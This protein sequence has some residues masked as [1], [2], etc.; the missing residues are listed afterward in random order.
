MPSIDRDPF[1]DGEALILA[2]SS[3]ISLYKLV[4]NRFLAMYRNRDVLSPACL[5][6][7]KEYML[8][9][10]NLDLSKFPETV[11]VQLKVGESWMQILW[12]Q[13]ALRG[14]SLSVSSPHLPLQ[15]HFPALLVSE[16]LQFCSGRSKDMVED[17]GI[18][19]VCDCPA[20]NYSPAWRVDWPMV[21]R[22]PPG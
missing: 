19:L 11:A 6:D 13:I 20:V 14:V 4:D 21:I 10:R 17:H 1:G 16:L 8:E 2:F 3:Y 18:C 15:I 7:L 12:W 22:D 9:P 5:D